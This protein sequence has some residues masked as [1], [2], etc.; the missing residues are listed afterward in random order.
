MWVQSLGQED[1]LAKQRATHSC[2]LAWRIPWTEVPG[3][4]QSTGVQRVRHNTRLSTHYTLHFGI[5]INDV[6]K[7]PINMKV[8]P[9]TV[10]PQFGWITREL[11]VNHIDPGLYPRDSDSSEP[12]GTTKVF[13]LGV[14]LSC[15]F[16]FFLSPWFKSVGRDLAVFCFCSSAIFWKIPGKIRLQLSDDPAGD[17]ILGFTDVIALQ[18]MDFSPTS[19]PS[20]ARFFFLI[21]LE[22]Y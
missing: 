18:F 12:K 3:G 13:A 22:T 2:I 9:L 20:A 10:A 4:L 11:S 8:L 17:S 1:P 5:T 7:N 16:F 6:R 21:P 14:W 19:A 15:L